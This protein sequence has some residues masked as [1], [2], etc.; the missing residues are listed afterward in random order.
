MPNAGKETQHLCGAAAEV[1][2]P[3]MRPVSLGVVLLYPAVV[4]GDQLFP[5]FGSVEVVIRHSAL[6]VECSFDEILPRLTALDL[7]FGYAQ[8]AVDRL[9][10]AGSE[11]P[12]SVTD[13]FLRRAISL[14]RGMENGQVG[15]EILTGGESARQYAA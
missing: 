13:E 11:D 5:A 3:P 14:H 4:C 1:L 12:A 15:G 7:L 9:G 8:R 6:N 10:L 2:P